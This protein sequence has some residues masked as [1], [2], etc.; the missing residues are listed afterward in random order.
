MQKYAASSVTDSQPDSFTD[1]TCGPVTH[2]GRGHQSESPQ[3]CIVV[4]SMTDAL[5]ALLQNVF[6]ELFTGLITEPKSRDEQGP[7]ADVLPFS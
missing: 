2:R 3:A 6:V 5:R 4:S 1:A 7:A